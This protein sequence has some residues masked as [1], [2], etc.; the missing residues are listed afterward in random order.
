MQPIGE[1]FSAKG[2]ESYSSLESTISDSVESISRSC[3]GIVSDRLQSHL[4]FVDEFESRKGKMAKCAKQHYG[5]RVQ[6]GQETSLRLPFISE[7]I[8]T[9]D[10]HFNIEYSFASLELSADQASANLKNGTTRN[11]L[12]SAI[13]P[14]Q[15]MTMTNAERISGGGCERAKQAKVVPPKPLSC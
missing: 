8:E 12:S 6:S 13:S 15:S 9:E 2:P 7:I 14:S 3:D 4:K 5:F 11:H 1:P 10:S